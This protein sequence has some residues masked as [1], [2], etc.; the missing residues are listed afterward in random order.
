ML[1][2]ALPAGVMADRF[3]RRKLL[4]AFQGGGAFVAVLLAAL[5]V[6]D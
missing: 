1:I 3:D 2:L 6:F 5:V 4:M